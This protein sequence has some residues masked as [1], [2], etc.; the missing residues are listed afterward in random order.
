MLTTHGLFV[1]GD[2]PLAHFSTIN[3]D[4]WGQ[5]KKFEPRVGELNDTFHG[6]KKS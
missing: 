5:Q 4:A 2:T 3:V 1:Q 6:G